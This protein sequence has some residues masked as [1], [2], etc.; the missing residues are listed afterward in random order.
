V[1]VRRTGL[2]KAQKARLA[3][4]DNRSAELADGWDIGALKALQADGVDLSNLWR[5][6]ELSELLGTE[7]KQGRTDPDAVPELRATSIKL[8]DLFQLGQHRL[9]CGDATS[10]EGAERVIAADKPTLCLTD[11]PYNVGRD[12]T[13]KTDDK[14]ADY[15]DW[16][17][18]W[19][20]LARAHC[21]N[22]AFSCGHPNV[23]MWAQIEPWKWII[24]WYKPAAMLGSPFGVS[25]WEP[26]LFYGTTRS[27]GRDVVEAPIVVDRDLDGHPVPKPIKFGEGLLTLLSD[28]SDIVYDPF[29]GSGT[30]LLAAERTK[31]VCCGMELEPSYCQVIIDRWEAFTGQKAEKLGEV[32]RAS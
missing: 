20:A 23:P 7:P 15:R 21:G 8:G 6:D 28:R 26:V 9:L 29:S 22:V 17:A 27:R 18:S 13:D 1:A 16:S 30:T 19:F 31:R 14:R 25:N 4:F 5:D 3:L 11:P 12:Y 32:V 2:S 24:C 10:P